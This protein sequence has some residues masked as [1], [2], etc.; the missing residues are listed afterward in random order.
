MRTAPRQLL[1]LA[2]AMS[3]WK[4]TSLE[5]PHWRFE[6]ARNVTKVLWASHFF[7]ASLNLAS[8]FSAALACHG[9]IRRPLF[10]DH[11][12]WM[13]AV[14]GMMVV[15]LYLFKHSVDL[16]IYRE[17]ERSREKA[18]ST[19]IFC[20]PMWGNNSCY[21]DRTQSLLHDSLADMQVE[22]QNPLSRHIV[23]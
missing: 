10:N 9:R 18:N 14:W 4:P 23:S 13:G 6:V 5:E 20:G 8:A 7:S 3:F 22:P 1:G 16:Y 21:E 15:C 2:I 12:K 11:Q 17:R 19:L